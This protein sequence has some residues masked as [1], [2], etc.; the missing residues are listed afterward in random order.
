M[1]CNVCNKDISVFKMKK[2]KDGYV[3]KDCLKNVPY[4]IQ[5]NSKALDLEDIY[6]FKDCELS[7][8]FIETSIY[9]NLK[10]DEI[11]S[12]I[13]INNDIFKCED[14]TDIGLVPESPKTKKQ[15]LVVD[16][17]IY[18]SLKQ[19]PLKF[20]VIV[21]HNAKCIYNSDK[22]TCELPKDYSIFCEML[23]NAL[24]MKAVCLNR[25]Y[26]RT[27]YNEL[28]L[29][30]ARFMVSDNYTLEEIRNTRN[31]LV[32]VFH[33]DNSNMGNE[34]I[35]IINRDYAILKEYLS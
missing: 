18:F 11:H 30:K 20:E 23:N 2:F 13:K 14:I 33:P 27:T 22:D 1:Y 7:K 21:K 35:Q 8:D 6:Y 16:I 26:A 3:C 32:K 25:L 15:E 9:G 24:S 17:K 19:L 34:K 10:L 4:L 28:N 29:A 5:K 12:L 31:L